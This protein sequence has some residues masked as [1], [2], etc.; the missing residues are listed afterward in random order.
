M[1]PIWQGSWHIKCK[2]LDHHI[3]LQVVN[4][5]KLRIWL[6]LWDE[7]EAS[8]SDFFG[9][10]KSSAGKVA[11][12]AD[13]MSRT[14]RANGEL[15]KI[16]GMMQAQ[17]IKLG[18]LYY[19]QRA[20]IGVTGSAYDEICQEIMNL[21]QQVEAKNAEIQ[22]INAD[23]YVPQ[24]TQTTAQPVPT[25][26]QSP[27]TPLPTQSTSPSAPPPSAATTK[28]CPNCGTEMPVATKFCPNCGT[29]V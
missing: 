17:Y 11:F 24:G 12:E 19:T 23:V 4:C 7:K 9:K 28:F 20:T 29:K 15:E 13:K 16:K 8:M 1:S 21:E 27:S 22:R 18:E 5:E 26:T 25:S 10:L 6:Y 3:T 2:F 14:S